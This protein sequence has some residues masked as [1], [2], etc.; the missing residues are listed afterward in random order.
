[1]VERADAQEVAARIHDRE[2]YADGLKLRGEDGG[3]STFPA[4]AETD[5]DEGRSYDRGAGRGVYDDRAA[6]DERRGS[7]PSD[8]PHW[9]LPHLDL[10]GMRWVF[11]GLAA[12]ALIAL[13]AFIGVA[14]AKRGPRPEAAPLAT[15]APAIEPGGEPLLPLDAGDPDALATEGRLEEAIVALLVQA[16]KRAGWHPDSERGRTAREVVTRLG[17]VDPRRAPLATIVGGAERVR[18]AGQPP[19]SALFETLR[20]E[21]DRL[22]E[23]P[24]TPTPEAKP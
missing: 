14:V 6:S 11:L 19:T 5:G 23:L 24:E 18:F 12:L 4:G 9:R 8:G 3:V 15:A 17:A 20:S 10:P 7:P 1:M 2:G 13:V 16:L 22:F 21:R